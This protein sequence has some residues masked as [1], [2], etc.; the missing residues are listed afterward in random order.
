M[1]SQPSTLALWQDTHVRL[2]YDCYGL[3]DLYEP[4]HQ[5]EWT[6]LSTWVGIIEASMQICLDLSKTSSALPPTNDGPI[7]R[8]M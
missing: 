1:S 3:Q 6:R 7:H 5:N 2:A 8:R 4:V